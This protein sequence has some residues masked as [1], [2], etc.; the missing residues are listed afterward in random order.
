VGI[1]YYPDTFSAILTKLMQVIY[2]TQ[3]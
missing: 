1:I 2:V 3:T